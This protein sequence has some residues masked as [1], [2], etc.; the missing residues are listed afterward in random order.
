MIPYY[1]TFILSCAFCLVGEQY[2]FMASAL[3]KNLKSHRKNRGI[4]IKLDFHNMRIN[5]AVF[6]LIISV[7]LVSILAGLRDYSVGTD[8]KTYGNDLFYYARGNISFSD[9]IDR[10]S[11]IEPLYLLL[12][13]VSAKISSSPHMLYFLTGLLIYGFMMA[14]MVKNS[15]TTS[16]TVSWFSFLCLLYGDTYNA[17]R[18]SLAI[19]VGFWA[20]EYFKENKYLKFSIGIIASFFLHNTAIIFL[21]I[22]FA[23]WILQ[24]NNKN[25]MK[26]LLVVGITFAMTAF[27]QLLTFFMDVGI[28]DTKMTRYFIDESAGFS[29]NAILIRL[30]FLALILFDRKKFWKKN[31]ERISGLKNDAEGDFYILMLALELVTVLMSSFVSS[32]YRVALYFVPFRCMAYSRF[33]MIG[34]NRKSRIIRS[35]ILLVYLLVIFI[36]QN[37]IKGNNEIYPYIFG[38][39]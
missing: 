29:V 23:Y 11:N 27:N 13:Y 34:M 39:L 31:N 4:K 6:F 17:M 15:K 1:I 24:K 33:C 18:Q 32:L 38:I 16:L 9:F 22:A 2:L 19:A 7:L 3:D 28:F 5:K 20:F 36:Y 12:V 30:P 10:L 37:Q 35:G 14:G 26:V 21:G 8:I 25:Y